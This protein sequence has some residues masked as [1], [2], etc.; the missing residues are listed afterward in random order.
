MLARTWVSSSGHQ[1]GAPVAR[2][3]GATAPTWSKCVWV[4]RIASTVV[5]PRAFAGL[6]DPLGLITGVEDHGAVGLR[7]AD[8]VAVLLHRP[9]CEHANVDH[10]AAFFLR[11]RRLP[12]VL[13]EVVARRDVQGEGEDGEQDSGQ[14]VALR[15]Q[16]QEQEHEPGG[17]QGAVDRALPGRRR[18][19][20]SF[21]RL[22]AS[23][24]LLLLLLGGGRRA[25]GA[26]ARGDRAG[27]GA[28]VLGPALALGLS[29]VLVREITRS[30]GRR[31]S[32]SSIV[33]RPRSGMPS[34]NPRSAAAG[35]SPTSSA[36]AGCAWRATASS[37][38]A[39]GVASGSSMLVDT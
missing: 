9:D 20:P 25:T 8:D 6:E 35:A 31:A 2:A 21:A 18:G 4:S 39:S 13:L 24:L 3:T 26:P 19:Q 28:A 5:I 17:Q 23:Q 37:T 30:R 38:A 15:G 7:P 14:D 29:H 1:T 10:L 36:V 22:L 33:P 32:A 16:E 34:G 12:Q 27:G 11:I